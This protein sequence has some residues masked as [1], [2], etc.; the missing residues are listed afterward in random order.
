MGLTNWQRYDIILLS[1][2]PYIKKE[3]EMIGGSLRAIEAIRDQRF[4]GIRLGERRNPPV[5]FEFGRQWHRF[6][7]E[8]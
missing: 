8:G 4:P 6:G 3:R 5:P 7:M 2:S 1:V